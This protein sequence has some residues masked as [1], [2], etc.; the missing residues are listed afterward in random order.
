MTEKYTQSSGKVATHNHTYQKM[1]NNPE[2]VNAPSNRGIGHQ[3]TETENR[4][5]KM[6]ENAS[7]N[8]IEIR[9]PAV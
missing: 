6:E 4:R 7:N 5:H 1:V 2:Y 9:N 8:W 3:I